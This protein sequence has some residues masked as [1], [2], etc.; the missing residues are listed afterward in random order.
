MSSFISL[1]ILD[2]TST[3]VIPPDSHNL[4][5]LMLEIERL[6]PFPFT[7]DLIVTVHLEK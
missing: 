4:D 1:R 6:K 3:P 7:P 2:H 5:A